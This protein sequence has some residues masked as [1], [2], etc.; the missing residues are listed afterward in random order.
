MVAVFISTPALFFCKLEN[1]KKKWWGSFYTDLTLKILCFCLVLEIKN[2]W[3][4]KKLGEETRSSFK[5]V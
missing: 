1:S 3:R 4:A 2:S 5:S